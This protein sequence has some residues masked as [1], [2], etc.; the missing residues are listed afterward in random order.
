MVLPGDGE[1]KCV[2]VALGTPLVSS[3]LRGDVEASARNL[4]ADR[5]ADPAARKDGGGDT[6]DEIAL[7][8]FGIE[9]VLAWTER[10]DRPMGSKRP[11]GMGT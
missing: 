6:E 1:S 8:N 7:L 5:S 10:S 11:S 2:R 9:E 3:S 4:A